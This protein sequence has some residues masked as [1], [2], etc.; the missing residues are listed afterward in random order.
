M[1]EE[2]R[3]IAIYLRK[4]EPRSVLRFTPKKNVAI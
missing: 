3:K 2:S 1:G 4:K